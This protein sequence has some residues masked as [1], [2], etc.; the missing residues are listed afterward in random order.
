[1]TASRLRTFVFLAG[2]LMVGAI[3]QAQQASQSSSA[4]A[5][6]PAQTASSPASSAAAA[7]KSAAAQPTKTAAA[8][9]SDE[10]ARLLKDAR[11]AGFKPEK[12]GGT[13][14]FCRTAVE[15]GSSFPVR[16]CYNSEQVAQ[17]IQEYQT[18]RNQLQQMHNTGMMSH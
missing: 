5:A 4:T 10:D 2:A 6:P 18:E 3:A 17:K 7:D 14:M 11:N 1:M 12:I 9:K 13:L 8:Q 16:T 15:L